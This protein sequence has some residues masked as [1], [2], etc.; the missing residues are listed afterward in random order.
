LEKKFK[1]ITMKYFIIFAFSIVNSL[2]SA[3]SEIEWMTENLSVTTFQNG[4]SIQQIVSE[5]DW[6]EAGNNKTPAW[7]YQYI[8]DSIQTIVYNYY[9][10]IDSRGLAPK[11]WKIPNI[12]E[13]EQMTIE[14]MGEKLCSSQNFGGAFSNSGLLIGFWS[15]TQ[16]DDGFAYFLEY[17]NMREEFK[18]DWVLKGLGFSVRCVR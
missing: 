5:E 18:S 16:Y 4:D 17:L 6:E 12:E 2:V 7:T 13:L 9:A 15:S 11:G 3:Q 10:V 8:N 14:I 1:K